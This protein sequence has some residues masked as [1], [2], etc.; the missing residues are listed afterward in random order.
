MEDVFFSHWLE[1]TRYGQGGDEAA[2]IG[3]KDPTA[4]SWTPYPELARGGEPHR[5]RGAPTARV[6]MACAMHQWEPAAS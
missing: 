6:P 4:G 2:T 3:F 5:A 1:K